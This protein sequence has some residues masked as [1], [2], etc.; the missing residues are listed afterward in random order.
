MLF[1]YYH[2]MGLYT[3]SPSN[4]SEISGSSNSENDESEGESDELSHYSDISVN[5]HPSDIRKSATPPIDERQLL[6]H[7]QVVMKDQS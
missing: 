7:L 3:F 2:S 6:L 5:S 4:S 1:E